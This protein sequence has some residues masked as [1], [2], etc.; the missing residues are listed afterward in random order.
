MLQIKEVAVVRGGTVIV[1]SVAC[2]IH[3]ITESTKGQAELSSP[4]VEKHTL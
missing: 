1:Q 3:D 4:E 2:D